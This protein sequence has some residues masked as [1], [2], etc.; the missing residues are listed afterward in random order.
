MWILG[1]LSQGALF[2][3]WDCR[4][5]ELVVV[6]KMRVT[7]QQQHGWTCADTD[8]PAAGLLTCCSHCGMCVTWRFHQVRLHRVLAVRFRSSSPFCSAENKRPVYL[9]RKQPQAAQSRRSQAGTVQ[10]IRSIFKMKQRVQT[11]NRVSLHK[12]DQKQTIYINT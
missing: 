7:T 10:R 1:F 2:H 5:S 8:G 6:P 11:P 9:W 12:T 3:A 4:D